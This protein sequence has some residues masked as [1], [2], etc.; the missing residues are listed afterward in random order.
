VYAQIMQQVGSKA[1]AEMATRL[2]VTA[3]VP[4]VNSVVL[5]TPEV[6]VLDMATAYSTF[7]NHG[8]KIP[9]Y[10][11][12]RVE[13]HGGKVLFDAGTPAKTQVVSPEVADTVTNVLRGVI[14]KGTGTKA[15]LKKVAA[16]KT[17]TTND[18]KD[19]WFVGYTCHVTTAVWVGFDIPTPMLNIQKVPAVTGGTIPANI[20]RAYMSKATAEESKCTYRNIDAGVNKLN[21][22]LVPGPPTTTTIAPPP[23]VPPPGGPTTPVTTPAS[24]GP[25]VTTALPAQPGATPQN[26]QAGVGAATG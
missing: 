8:V 2:G 26:A 17:G 14:Q 9:P 18:N 23:T 20:W 21:P 1:V 12:Q 24:G 10:L 25:A 11:I 4:P 15:L 16:G 19:A 22:L 3:P 6:S 5:G 7:A 13:T